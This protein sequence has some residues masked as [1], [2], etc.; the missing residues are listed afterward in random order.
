[1]SVY[2]VIQTGGK[3]YR[4]APGEVVRVE[5]LAA[6]PGETVEFDEVSLL[7]TGQEVHVG[8]PV[9]EGA[10]VRAQVLKEAR[11]E[12]IIVFKKRKRKGYRKTAG[13]RQYFTELRINE[14][15]FNSDVFRAQ[16]KGQQRAR[17]TGVEATA[18]AGPKK[19][20][21]AQQSEK[22]KGP[23][24]KNASFINK[25]KGNSEK[26]ELFRPTEQLHAADG[27]TD[28]PALVERAPSPGAD[29]A[30]AGQRIARTEEKQD[31][32]PAEPLASPA[33]EQAPPLPVR[34]EDLPSSPLRSE[35]PEMPAAS[36]RRRT[37]I[38]IAAALLL[39]IILLLWGKGPF[40]GP[41]ST[42]A[43]VPMTMQ[44]A[45]KGP[46][47]AALPVPEK[48]IKDTTPVDKPSAPAQP[49]D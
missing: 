1:M 7:A 26:A 6:G 8:R 9:L 5:K 3:Q 40:S 28:A 36:S 45:D 39:L 29:N 4:I 30:A 46:K 38:A 25:D 37:F 23:A 49:P 44:P 43:P 19:S 2:A 13:H 27:M 24:R 42:L 48:T 34:G 22:K 33:G 41:Q 11:G 10:R 12:K 18:P 31:A 15:L 16:E 32:R 17:K 35:A 47:K 20:G 21:A 14:I